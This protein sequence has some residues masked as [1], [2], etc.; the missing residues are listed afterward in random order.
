MNADDQDWTAQE[1]AQLRA[2]RLDRAPREALE[3]A[4]IGR[5]AGRGLIGRARPVPWARMLAALTAAAALFGGGL[6]L[7]SRSGRATGPPD[8]PRYLLLLEGADTGTV[9]E[10]QQR[11]GEYRAWARREARAG[12]LLSGEK[13]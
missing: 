3:R 2:L 12:R 8:L 5:I 13:L 11:V 1:R 4:V 9:E 10:E 6:L 7:G